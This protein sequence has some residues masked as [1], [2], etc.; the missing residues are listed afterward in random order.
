VGSHADGSSGGGHSFDAAWKVVGDSF[1]DK[2]NVGAFLPVDCV[3]EENDDVLFHASELSLAVCGVDPTCL[4]SAGLLPSPASED[5]LEASP[6]SPRASSVDPLCSPR[7]V[8]DVFQVSLSPVSKMGALET[9]D[10]QQLLGG[11]LPSRDF[12]SFRDSCRRSISPALP[13]P[14]ARRCRPKKMYAGPVRRSRRIGG[15]FA[16]G[17]LIR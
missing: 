9:M 17:T 15:R 12:A 7:S 2:E 13:R 16:M 11:Q 8:M 5:D 14:S 10:C 6:G 1:F 4:S 3:F